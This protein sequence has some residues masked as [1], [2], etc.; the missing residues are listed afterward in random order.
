MDAQILIDSRAARA[1]FWNRPYCAPAPLITRDPVPAPRDPG[2]D[3]RATPSGFTLIEL[4]IVVLVIGILAAIAIPNFVQMQKR[5]GEGAVKSNM[6]TL[7][8]TIEDFSLL[9]DGTYPVDAAA[10]CIDGRSL[11]QVCP[12]GAFPRNPFTRAAS[13]VQWNADPGAGNKGEMAINPAL[14]SNYTV[15]ANGADGVA[16]VLT[17]SSGN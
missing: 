3:D 5:A 1:T 4:M 14:V 9:N 6:H 11:A 17:L 7:Q 12:T 13:V 2:S 8:M 15:K 16:L 10:T